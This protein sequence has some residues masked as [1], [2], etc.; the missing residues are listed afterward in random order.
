MTSE[1]IPVMATP[2]MAAA[3]AVGG[4]AGLVGGAV[5]MANAAE[6]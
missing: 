2:A 3:G 4:A 5:G 1:A 6:D